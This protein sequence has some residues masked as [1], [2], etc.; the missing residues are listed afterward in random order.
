MLQ[1]DVLEG[2]AGLLWAAVAA[3]EAGQRGEPSQGDEPEAQASG[4][5]GAPPG[6]GDSAGD[7][8]S[9]VGGQW[10]MPFVGCLRTHAASPSPAGCRPL[11]PLCPRRPV[12]QRPQECKR[13]R[14]KSVRRR[15][16]RAAAARSAAYVRRERALM[17][18]WVALLQRMDHTAAR[19]QAAA[20][21]AA[22]A[23]EPPGVVPALPAPS[24][25]LPLLHGLPVVPAPPRAGA[26]AGDAQ[27]SSASAAGGGGSGA[28]AVDVVVGCGAGGKGSPQPEGGGGAE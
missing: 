18:E 22:Q 15:C 1:R 24:A 3:E 20:A 16:V 5:G 9:G 13:L 26:R 25:T 28:L 23:E 10:A 12:R 27:P 11:P 2:V 6:A 7:T 4:R 14:L 19:A 8:G 17:E 21:A